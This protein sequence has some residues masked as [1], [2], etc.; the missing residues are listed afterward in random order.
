[1]DEFELRREMV[2]ACRRMNEIGLNQGTSGNVSARCGDKILITPT[3]LPYDDMQPEDIVAM[4]VDGS[5]EGKRKP[6]SE[7]RFHHDILSNRTDIDAVLHC[8][9]AYAVAM[10]C[11][12]LDINSFHY[13]VAVAGGTNIRCAPYATFGTQALSDAALEALEGRKACLLG[14]H[15]QIAL[16]STIKQAF[17]LAIEVET[18]AKMYVTARLLGEPPVLSEEEMGRVMNQMKQMTYGV[19]RNPS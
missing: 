16:G 9:S 1:M 5:F 18:L 7:W 17:A 19:T 2:A 13:M 11:H 12:H 3:S 10:A 6:S 8:H 15:G 4:N 14:Q